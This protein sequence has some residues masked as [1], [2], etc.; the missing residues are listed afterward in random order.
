[1]RSEMAATIAEVRGE[2]AAKGTYSAE[3]IVG[4]AAAQIEHG[5]L[6]DARTT[7]SVPSRHHLRPGGDALPK[8][9]TPEQRDQLRRLATRAELK[10]MV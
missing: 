3:L 7:E 5:A 4:P 1:M 9:P 8:D 2:L 10:R 6:A